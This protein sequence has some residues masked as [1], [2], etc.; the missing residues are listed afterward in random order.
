MDGVL[1]RR[2]G[3]AGAAVILRTGAAA[4]QREPSPHVA[5]SI[6]DP[7]HCV[8]Q[9]NPDDHPCAEPPTSSPAQT[10]R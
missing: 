6:D 2:A 8:H 5:G 10:L 3:V 1:V 9:E 4:S 7:T